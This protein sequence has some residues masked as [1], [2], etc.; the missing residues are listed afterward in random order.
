MRFLGEP[1]R[2][3]PGGRD[4]AALTVCK[5]FDSEHRISR[6]QLH[7]WT[8]LFAGCKKLISRENVVGGHA[9]TLHIPEVGVFGNSNMMMLGKNNLQVADLILKW[10]DK[11]VKVKKQGGDAAHHNITTMRN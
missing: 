4:A 2:N 5:D 3:K 9:S 8:S 10:I 1:V 11:H 7:P 6:W